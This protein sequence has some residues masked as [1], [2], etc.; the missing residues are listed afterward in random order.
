[1]GNIYK[2]YC[3][4]HVHYETLDFYLGLEMQYKSASQDCAEHKVKS[5]FGQIQNIIPLYLQLF[6]SKYPFLKLIIEEEFCTILY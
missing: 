1:M 6:S 2:K 5:I 4:S 3:T